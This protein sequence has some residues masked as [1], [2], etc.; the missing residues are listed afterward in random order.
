MT[1]PEPPIKLEG[2][3]S[4]ISGNTLYVYSSNGFISLPLKANSTGWATLNGGVSVSNPVCLKGGI[5]GSESDDEALYVVGGTTTS[6][7]TYPGLQRYSFKDRSWTTLGNGA[8]TSMSARTGHGAAFVASN[9]S[10]IVYAGNQGSGDSTALSA[11]SFLISTKSP[12]VPTS[13][14]CQEAP[15]LNNPQLLPWNSTHVGMFGGTGGSQAVYTYS[16]SEGWITS[17]VSLQ[18]ALSTSNPLTLLSGSGDS[19][20]LEFFDMSA[21][22]NSVTNY[23]LVS[24]DG[25]PDSPA[26]AVGSSSK[27]R[28]TGSYPAYNDTLAPSYTWSDYGLA[29][30]SNG[31]VVLSSG[32]SNNSLAIFN[33]T[34]NS[35][36]NATEF[37]YGKTVQH[38]LKTN[39]TTST[40]MTPTATATPS[41][42]IS[43]SATPSSTTT[44]AAAASGGSHTDVKVIIGAVLGSVCGVGIILLLLLWLLKRERTKRERNGQARGGDSKDRLSF[45][46]Q[47]IEPLAGG[48]YPMAKSPVPVASM[49]ADSLAI[50]SGKYA[51]EKSLMPPPTNAGYGLSATPRKSSPLSPIPSSGLAPSSMYS[52]DAYRHSNTPSELGNKPGDRTTDEGWGK[53]FED[54][55]TT[56]LAG[57]AAD[58][59]TTSSIYTKSD[60]RGSAWPMSNLTPL[61]LG[62]LDQPKPLGRVYS[63]SPTT[64]HASSSRSLAIPEGQSA[65]IS[66]ADSIS[67]TSDDDP[68]DTNWTGAHTSWLGRPASSNYSTSFYN[69]SSR[70]LPSSNPQLPRHSNGRRSSIAIPDDI[71]ELPVPGRNNVNSDM[72]WLNIHADR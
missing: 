35:W 26:V 51:G 48:A 55:N 16:L 24:S 32:K 59:S 72:S 9:S 69:S 57:M 13:V 11:E 28:S 36:V 22:P 1:V 45:Q 7:D 63:G 50:I 5:D 42:S 49:S 71:D 62:F 14:N 56:N 17:P 29:Q 39:T 23:E 43:A 30:G 19:K 8:A 12:W 38:V 34:S 44:A 33:Q 31:L 70:D 40:T 60:Y 66:S 3:C 4:V 18:S 58:R 46:D 54:N 21:S 52:E 6:D 61:N 67:V 2:H 68:H 41:A 47:G 15:T 53:Y 37:F 10:I 65:R 20:V 27:K 25:N 64:E